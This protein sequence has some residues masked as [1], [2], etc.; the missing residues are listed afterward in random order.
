MS[1]RYIA[2]GSS[3]RSPIRNAV[4]GE[5]GAEQ[6]VERL[7]GRLEVADDQRAD[8]LCLAVVGV[9]VPGRERVGAEHDPALDLVAEPLASRPRNHVHDVAR[10]RGAVAVPDPVVPREVRGASAGAIR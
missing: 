4:V 2:S 3:A 1:E 5:V 6:Q 9:V 10:V 8:L 7:E